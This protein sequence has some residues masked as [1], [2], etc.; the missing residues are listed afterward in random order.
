M[1]TLSSEISSLLILPSPTDGVCV[2]TLYFPVT[3]QACVLPVH[4]CIFTPNDLIPH[5]HFSFPP[6]LWVPAHLFTNPLSQLA[7]S[8]Q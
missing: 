5:N 3:L 6:A 2:E 4:V 7:H 1:E 8:T